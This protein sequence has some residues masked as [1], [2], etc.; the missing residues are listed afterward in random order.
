MTTTSKT[1]KAV[2]SKIADELRSM[3]ARGTLSPGMRLGQTDLATQFDASRVPV[4]EA[5]KLL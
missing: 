1:S 4:R 5:L 3:I 2:P